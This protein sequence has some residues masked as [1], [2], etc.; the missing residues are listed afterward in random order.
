MRAQHVL[1]VNAWLL[2]FYRLLF[3]FVGN[4]TM[5]P[6]FFLA[7]L[8]PLFSS[9]LFRFVYIAAGKIASGNYLQDC[10]AD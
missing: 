7:V 10:D 8:L 1:S 6:D 3:L 5:K 4:V 9:L 2:A